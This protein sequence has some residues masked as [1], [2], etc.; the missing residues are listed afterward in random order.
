MALR[1]LDV[2]VDVEVDGSEL[3]IVNQQVDDLVDTLEKLDKVYDIN[4]DL[5][6]GNALVQIEKLEQKLREIDNR[7]NIHI[8]LDTFG[9]ITTLE[10]VLSSLEHERINVKVDLDITDAESRIAMIEAELQALAA[11]SINIDVDTTGAMAQIAV[12]QA[13]IAALDT[14]SVDINIDSASLQA[15]IIT[16]QAQLDALNNNPPDVDIH[17]QA[18]D[19]I[20]E[21]QRI[22]NRVDTLDG[23]DIFIDVDIDTLSN[24]ILALRAQIQY[25]EASG[26]NLN[27]DTAAAHAQLAAMQAHLQALQM[28]ANAVNVGSGMLGMFAGFNPVGFA[29]GAGLFLAVLG[30]ILTILPPLAIAIN[31]VIGAVGVLG[32]ALGVLGG[33]AL[34]LG[35]ALVVG[36]AG[37]MGFGAIAIS[38]IVGLYDEKAKLTASQRELKAETDKVITSWQGLKTALEPAVFDAAKSGVKAINTLL[39]QSQ[40]ILK[41]AGGAVGDLM[42]NFNKSL[43]GNEMQSFFSMLKQDIGPITT[44]LGNGFGN[45]LKGVANTMTAL[46]PLTR[47]VSQGFE[48]MM[49]SFANWTSGLIGSNK[50]ETFMDYIKTNAPKI[51]SALGHATTGITKFFAGFSG[52]GSDAFTWFQDKMVQF[53]SWA[54][55]LGNNAG[56]QNFLDGIRENAPVV[57][58]ILRELGGSLKTFWTIM[59]DD[60]GGASRLESFANGLKHL[61][62]ALKDQNLQDVISGAFTFDISKI[63]GGLTGGAQSGGFGAVEGQIEKNVSETFKNG[64]LKGITNG[65]TNLSATGLVGKALNGLI[66]KM[67]GGSETTSEPLPDAVVENFTQGAMKQVEN[68][69]NGGGSAPYSAELGMFKEIEI[70]VGANTTPAEAAIEGVTQG[71]EIEARVNADTSKAEQQL[72]EVGSAKEI[73]AKVDADTAAAQSKLNALDA[74]PIKISTDTSAISAQIGSMAATIQL[75]ANTSAIRNEIQNMPGANIKL[76]AD[77]TSLQNSISNLDANVTLKAKK[78]DITNNLVQPVNLPITPIMKKTDHL[79]GGAPATMEVTP[80]I[81]KMPKLDPISVDV[82]LNVNNSAIGNLSAGIKVTFPPMPKFNWPSMPKFSWPPLPKFSWPPLPKFSWPPLPKWSWP[83]YPRFSWPP[84]PKFSWPPM[85]TVKV[86]VS[87]A[88]NGSHATG[89]GRVPFD[90]YVGN[91]HKDESVLT[92]V[93][94]DQLRSIGALKGNGESPELDMSAIAN[95]NP[96]STANN[97]QS[98]SSKVNNSKSSSSTNHYNI[99]VQVDG[100]KS[101][102]ETGASVVEQLQNWVAS[103]EDA[104]PSVYEF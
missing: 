36:A 94:S 80:K 29:V 2:E 5:D 1:D 87:G 83:A 28:Q 45:A 65:A 53:D 21:L 33:A 91:L 41:K 10:A 97:P 93:Q 23:D 81:T 39:E 68:A 4:I 99:N 57:G 12:L 103:L 8:D 98:R 96:A 100:S 22:Q 95:Y 35:S 62:N 71:K 64:I 9:E 38:S 101:P 40:P 24:D 6:D 104:N 85:P 47:W 75:N 31:V 70:D 7:I 11:T 51:G 63:V 102:Q 49:G 73:Q 88:A 61:G 18:A 3:V 37:L 58:D 77:K 17:V 50:M 25:F 20:V 78:I 13:Q 76:T 59:T 32:V 74:T 66:G 19:A 86:N 84:L 92:A 52:V 48:N 43:K 55:G 82:K 30:A 46:S 69:M 79:F 27:I 90:N 15:Q 60:S 54:S 89:L 42:D 26:I 67:F 44:N 14:G 56:F 34:A 16:L 72:D